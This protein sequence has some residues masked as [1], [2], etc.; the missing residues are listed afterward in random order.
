[1][2]YDVSLLTVFW[3]LLCASV[4]CFLL[5]AC[6]DAGSNVFVP[7]SDI[8]V[9]AFLFGQLTSCILLWLTHSVVA[10]QITHS[11]ISEVELAAA[12]ESYQQVRTT[13]TEHKLIQV[14]CVM[15]LVL[16]SLLQC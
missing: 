7:D 6:D 5:H 1:M 2:H 11:G 4:L 14:W 8:S 12:H 10:I 16:R 15:C 9:S 3:L 13:Y